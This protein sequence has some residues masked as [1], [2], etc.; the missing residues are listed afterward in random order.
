MNELIAAM[1]NSFENRFPEVDNNPGDTYF[2]TALS[3][4]YAPY[5]QDDLEV[6]KGEIFG[7]YGL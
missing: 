7:L 2:G 1:V 3:M 6:K 4:K 5:L